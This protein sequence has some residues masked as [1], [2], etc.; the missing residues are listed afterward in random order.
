MCKQFIQSDCK[1]S[2]SLYLSVFVSVQCTQNHLNIFTK[3]YQLSYA[4]IFSTLSFRN[5]TKDLPAE[6]LSVKL[7]H[8]I[9]INAYSWGNDCLALQQFQKC[10]RSIYFH[11]ISS[12]HW[13]HSH[14]FLEYICLDKSTSYKTPF[15][16]YIKF[17]IK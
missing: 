16:Y 13:M 15:T 9:H 1:Q 8:H 2:L 17:I 11:S 5:C 14:Y 10:Y 7:L 12:N 4:K 3:V 6:W